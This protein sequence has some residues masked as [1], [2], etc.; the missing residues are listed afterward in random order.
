[1]PLGAEG[2]L[3]FSAMAIVG[4]SSSD[5]TRST[6]SDLLRRF[7]TTVVSLSISIRAAVR[8]SARSLRDSRAP[9]E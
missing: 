3:P 2:E 1:M 5:P 7:S 6:P 8:V 4:S 9:S